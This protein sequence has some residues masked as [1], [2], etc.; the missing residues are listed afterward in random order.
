MH[1]TIRAAF[2]LVLLL[3]TSALMTAASEGPQTQRLD[4]DSSLRCHALLK[5][6]ADLNGEQAHPSVREGV[7]QARL[8]ARL[9]GDEQGKS[10]QTTLAD[11]A[12]EVTRRHQQ[13]EATDLR[14]ESAVTAI[15]AEI[16]QCLQLIAA[17]Q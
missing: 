12:T 8:L 13:L 11:L 10:L 15:G 2:S 4:Y 7:M 1:R 3:S 5:Y 17:T 16:N 14:Q 6:F 9:Y